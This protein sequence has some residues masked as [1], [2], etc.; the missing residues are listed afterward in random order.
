M[1]NVFRQRGLSS[2]I[3]GVIIIATILVFVIQFRPNANQQ[4]ASLKEACVVLVKGHCVNPK[5]YKAAYRLLI[6]R[7]QSGNLLT[8]RARQMGLGKITAD[9]LVERELLISEADRIGLRVTQDEVQDEILSGFIHV[10]VPSENP[11][12][13][14][15]LR[16]MDGKIYAGFKDPKTKQFDYKIYERNIRMLTGKSATEFREEQERELVAAKMR[17]MVTSPIRVSDAEALEMYVA[18]KSSAKIAYVPVKAEWVGRYAVKATQAD[19]DA[20][21][22][23]VSNAQLVDATMEQRKK[24]SLPVKDH[25]RHILIKTPP[26]ASDEDKALALGRLARAAQRIKEGEAFA[27]VARD[28]SDDKGSAMRGGDV[29]DKTDPF[30]APFKAAAD[31]L[32]PGEMT[33][34]AIETQFG[35]HLI[36]KDDP[37]KSAEVEAALKKDAARALYVKSGAFEL[38]KTIAA[39]IATDIKAGKTPDDAAKAAIAPYVTKETVPALAVRS[40]DEPA[41]GGKDGKDGTVATDAGTRPEGDAATASADGGAAKPDEKKTIVAKAPTADNDPDRPQAQVSSSFNEGGEAIA[42]LSGE[43]S[44]SV[45][46]FAFAG[47]EGELM[48][49]PLRTDDGY[50]AVQLKEHKAA[51]KEEFEKD[52]ETYVQTLLAKK[53]AEALALYVKRLKETA[54][55]DIKIDETYTKEQAKDGGAPSDEEDEGY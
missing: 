48:S 6:P 52:R 53:Q 55:A 3:Y 54:K 37:A 23:D 39:K 26:T 31:A 9:G 32:K 2:L 14:Y 40:S 20:W 19:V 33:P 10:S 1:L 4:T 5:S 27:D 16:V 24:D 50:A 38:A 47:K 12:L 21:L 41:R 46:K 43:A 17:E 11:N 8:A 44:A 18:E 35:Y 13:A 45:N 36:M 22:K 28:V 30:V 42:E 49:E 29:G 7:D 51:T 34:D 15:S 25:I